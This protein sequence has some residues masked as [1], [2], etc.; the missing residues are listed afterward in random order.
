MDPESYQDDDILTSLA[1]V[2]PLA[3]AG[4]V[5]AA[6]CWTLFAVA[7]VHVRETL[8]LSNVQFGL[9]LA[10]PMAAGAL[11]AVPA[12]LLAQRLGA[13]RVMVACL[14][15]LAVCMVLIVLARSFTGY[16]LASAGLGLAAGFYSAGL[17]FVTRHSPYE[18]IGLVLGI[19]GAGVTG[20]GF[21][22]Y[23]VPLIH[24]AFAWQGVALAYLT[25][26]LLVLA[27][28]LLLTDNADSDSD[29]AEA[30]VSQ[31][32][33]RLRTLRMWQLCLYFGVV[34]GSFFTLA[35]WLPDY[36]SSRFTLTVES[37]AKLALWFVIP[38]ALAQ[39]AGGGL[40]DRFGTARVVV[41][42][43]AVCLMV[44]FV[45]SY[46]PMTLFIQGVEQTLE[47]K[48]AMP[49]YL[50]RIFVL[51]LGIALGCAM[52][53]LQRMMIAENR[54]GAAFAA[55]MLLVSACSVAFLLPLLFGGV[56]QWLGVRSA[57][58]MILF[59]LFAGCLFLFARGQRRSE[60]QALLHT[61]I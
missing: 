25:V 31:L 30:T 50:E 49:L 57:V 59:L 15:G 11:L 51:V 44:L 14:A 26:L 17:Q 34:A 19:F 41:R 4:F 18:H 56:N 29:P 7:G 9:L 45:L 40:S 21:N 32:L 5:V 3:L 55:G 43:L 61:G 53:G 8:N 52:G 35:L 39:I 36:L 6:G 28:L 47:L 22:Y 46:P 13:R 12:G 23:L 42:A 10:M 58:F 60:R 2:L 54:D 24:Q 33:M 16:L 48:L 20:A 1:V 27:L 38:G 37:G